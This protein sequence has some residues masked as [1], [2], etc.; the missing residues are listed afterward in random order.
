MEKQ[1]TC[2]GWVDHWLLHMNLLV[3]VIEQA[4]V[5]AV[6]IT[7]LLK[8]KNSINPNWYTIPHLP[9]F[10]WEFQNSSDA[11]SKDGSLSCGI[12]SSFFTPDIH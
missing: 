1:N 9:T 7:L 5:V 6:W 12:A 8:R 3:L 4:T 10:E 2:E 11:C